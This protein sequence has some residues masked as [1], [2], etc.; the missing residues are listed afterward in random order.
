MTKIFY[1]EKIVESFRGWFESRW[2][3]KKF[4]SKLLIIRSP[5]AFGAGSSPGGPARCGFFMIVCYVYILHS[6]KLDRYYT[7]FTT[8]KPE[9]RL[10]NHLNLY[11]HKDKYTAKADDWELFITIKCESHQQAHSI[12]R[13]I[14]RMKSKVYIQNLKKYPEIIERLLKKHS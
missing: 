4:A 13:H 3:H 11:Y 2:A 7:G 12:E 10:E 8:L 6:K 9:Q 14:K 5:K 1:R